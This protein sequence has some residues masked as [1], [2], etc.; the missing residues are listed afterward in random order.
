MCWIAK[1]QY[2]YSLICALRVRQTHNSIIDCISLRKSVDNINFRYYEGQ[3]N[4]NRTSGK[5]WQW[6]LFYSKVSARS[7]NTFISLGD[8]TINSSLAERARSLMDP[9]PHPL[10]H[11]LVRMKPLTSTN[12]FLRVAQNVEVTRGKIWDVWRMLKCF[13]AKSLKLIPQ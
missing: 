1:I 7:V 6:N 13:P 11:F 3:S 4:D 12:V 5:K 8:G 2:T 9:Q 10:L